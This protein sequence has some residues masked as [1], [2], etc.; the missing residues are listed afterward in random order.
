[1]MIYDTSR[2]DKLGIIQ[3]WMRPIFRN[4][5]KSLGPFRYD[6]IRYDWIQYDMIRCNS[7]YRY[8]MIRYDT[9]YRYDTIQ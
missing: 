3:R 1:M 8:D 7:V 9:I 5:T 6:T 2:Y 4:E